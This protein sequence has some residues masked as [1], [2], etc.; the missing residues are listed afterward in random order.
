MPDKSG[1]FSEVEQ[2][3]R[4]LWNNQLN[5]TPGP[6]LPVGMND[7]E[8][9]TTIRMPPRP[10]HAPGFQKD[11]FAVGST[12]L[13]R[14]LRQLLGIAPELR[15]R[16]NQVQQGPTSDVGNE[17]ARIYPLQFPE[18]RLTPDQFGTLNLLGLTN[19]KTGN[20][21]LNP[22]LGLPGHEDPQDVLAHE[23]THAAGYQSHEG[24]MQD[25]AADLSSKLRL[26]KPK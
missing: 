12:E 9:S 1:K 8:G 16:V 15:E 3:L 22:T 5:T 21:S 4:E 14:M 18:P 2:R 10:A 24:G 23:L 25:E 6:T 19:M 26:K 11:P 17:L 13:A 7:P 20:I